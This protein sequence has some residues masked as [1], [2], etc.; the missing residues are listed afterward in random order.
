VNPFRT[1]RARLF[2]AIAAT[3]AVSVGS[4]LAVDG[5]LSHRAVERAT[6]RDLAHQADL[7]AG[8]ER[9]SVAPLVHLK[10][11]RAF[12]ARLGERV[13]TAPLDRPSPYFDADELADLRAGR[14]LHGSVELGNTSYLYA[15]RPIGNRAFVLLRPKRLTGTTWRPFLDALVIAAAIGA[16]LAALVSILL[17]RGI[18]G[19]VRSVVTATRALAGSGSAPPVPEDGPRSSSRSRARSTTSR[20]SSRGHGMRSGHSCSR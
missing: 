19:P 8:R 20:T 3:V 6:E 5:V 12:A 10:S 4:I 15:A 2:V 7:L 11:L 16:A 17:A 14:S 18:A 9:A 1:L 13:A